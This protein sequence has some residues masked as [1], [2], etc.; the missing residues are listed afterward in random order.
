MTAESVENWVRAVA[1]LDMVKVQ[2]VRALAADPARVVAD[3][4]RAVDPAS[5]MVQGGVVE[6]QVTVTAQ[7]DPVTTE[8]SG[9]VM[10]LAPW[11]QLMAQ[12]V[13][14]MAA[15]LDPMGDPGPVPVPW[16]PNTALVFQVTGDPDGSGLE[17]ALPFRGA[18]VNVHVLVLETGGT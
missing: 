3:R 10:G 9:P 2:E 15:T 17:D 1:V 18:F 8:A 13:P 16:A 7:V 12:V 14:A 6:V 5:A 4:V 11:V